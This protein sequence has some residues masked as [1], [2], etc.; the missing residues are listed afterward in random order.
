MSKAWL[1]EA[2]RMYDGL[3]T[4]QVIDE[5]HALAMQMIAV[6]AQQAGRDQG[7]VGKQQGG[8][9]GQVSPEAN[10]AQA[11]TAGAPDTAGIVSG[12]MGGM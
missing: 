10:G 6:N 1:N 2:A 8:K 5:V 11:A 4:K 12:M 9:K 3:L 7:A